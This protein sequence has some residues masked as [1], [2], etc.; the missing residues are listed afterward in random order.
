[1]R[2][3]W[4]LLVSVGVLLGV[5][6]LIGLLAFGEDSDAGGAPGAV[7]AVERPPVVFVSGT[8][9]W[10]HGEP[11]SGA[12]LE[13]QLTSPDDRH[14]VPLP[15]VGAVETDDEGAFVVELPADTMLYVGITSD[16][17]EL[18]ED[19][20]LKTFTS[21]TQRVEYVLPSAC[22]LRVAGLFPLV[23]GWPDAK[24]ILMAK[25][26][27]TPLGRILLKDWL[28]R[29]SGIAMGTVVGVVLVVGD[30]APQAFALAQDVEIVERD[31]RIRVELPESLASRLFGEQAGVVANE[32]AVEPWT[33]SWSL[34]D[35]SGAAVDGRSLVSSGVLADSGY[36]D[37]RLV[38]ADGTEASQDQHLSYWNAD[39]EGEVTVSLAAP[40]EVE[41]RIAGRTFREVGVMPGEWIRFI[42]H[43]P[44]EADHPVTVIYEPESVPVLIMAFG[45][46]GSRYLNVSESGSLEGRYADGRYA[47][48]A[49]SGDPGVSTTGTFVVDAS[50]G[51]VRVPIV[52]SESASLSGHLFPAPPEG[53]T[54]TVQ[55]MRRG[56]V[57]FM[58]VLQGEA[59][60]LDGL[61]EIA[62]LGTGEHVVTVASR[63]KDQVRVAHVGVDLK[64]GSNRV[65]VDRPSDAASEKLTLVLEGAEA[66][67]VRAFDAEGRQV[68]FL[69]SEG[70]PVTL[71]TPSPA[72]SYV[73]VTAGEMWRTGE[74]TH[75]EV[76]GAK[77]V[78]SF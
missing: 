8:V 37:V 78:L 56:A 33:F 64:A 9:A 63:R 17:L 74:M 39:L 1:M 21:A 71:I 50:A 16:A 42:L 13:F 4:R 15:A 3:V 72:V 11:V 69:M 28:G 54:A 7:T 29:F 53:E 55:V 40:V 61:F 73:A 75:G 25:G 5:A 2:L 67:H 32:A 57:G 44:F 62:G 76:T 10:E 65:D 20:R 46:D 43:E 31:Q 35:P 60:G 24:V 45:E 26:E 66:A 34:V 77:L 18:R 48:H 30:R 38:A 41:L 27:E 51:P 36:V 59:S 52:F 19:R 58:P 12:R 70:K 6:G 22:V 47:Y 68:T 49:A 23:D 14:A